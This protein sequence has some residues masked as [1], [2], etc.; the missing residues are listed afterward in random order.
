M[1]SV[2]QW[3]EVRRMRRARPHRTGDHSMS[4]EQSPDARQRDDESDRGL[5]RRDRHRALLA[6]E[7]REATEVDGG[8]RHQAWDAPAPICC[9]QAL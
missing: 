3:A 7:M 1:V 4:Y 5:T 2:E 8:G 9:Q 6:N